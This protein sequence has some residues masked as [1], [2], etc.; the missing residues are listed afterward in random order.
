M[1]ESDRQRTQWDYS[2]LFVDAEPFFQRLLNCVG[3]AERT[4]DFEYYIFERDFLGQRFQEALQEGRP[5]GIDHL[6]V[7]PIIKQGNASFFDRL[8]DWRPAIRRVRQSQTGPPHREHEH[9]GLR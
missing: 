3:Q 2:R 7:A 9:L 6:L 8:T 4:I 1:A 5:L